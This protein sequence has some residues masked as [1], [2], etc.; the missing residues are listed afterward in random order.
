MDSHPI[1]GEKTTETGISSGLLSHLARMQSL[2]YTVNNILTSNV[3][4]ATYSFSYLRSQ[5]DTFHPAI[6]INA[7]Q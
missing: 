5:F 4:R 1:Q 6:S 3:C 7:N 2:L